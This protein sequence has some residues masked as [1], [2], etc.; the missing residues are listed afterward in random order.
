MKIYKDMTFHDFKEE[1]ADCLG[2]TAEEL[3]ENTN[4]LT[5]LGIDSLSLVNTMI[6]I[7]AEN[8]IKFTAEER[9]MVQNLGKIFE[10]LMKNLNEGEI[11]D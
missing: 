1:F 10:I 3:N 8:D 4:L 5:D 11:K 9:I 7:E 2:I 6:R